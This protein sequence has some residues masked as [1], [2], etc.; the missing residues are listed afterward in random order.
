MIT[1]NNKTD[2]IVTI[3]TQLVSIRT[4]KTEVEAMKWIENY[5]KQYTEKYDLSVTRQDIDDQ[6]RYNLIVSNTKKPKLLL[7]WHLDTVPVVNEQ[8]L[9]PTIQE[10]KL[11]GRG[12]LDMKSW[13]A[14]MIAMLPALLEKEIP[15]MMLFYCDEEYNF[16]GMKKF[17]K[18]YQWMIEPD[19]VI[20]PEW[21]NQS[22]L[23][24][25]RWI[26][27]FTCSVGGQS[28]HAARKHLGRNAIEWAVAL[29]AFLEKELQ[30][31][32]ESF[33]TT[34]NLGGL[35]GGL[36][37]GDSIIQKANVVPNIANCIYDIRLGGK[38]K[39]KDLWMLI[40]Q[41]CTQTGYT[42][43]NVSINFWLGSLIQDEISR[44]YQQFSSV[45]TGTNS[46]Y[47][48]IQ[49]INET[50]GGDCLQIGPSPREQA[51]QVGEYVSID[52]LQKTYDIIREVIMKKV[53]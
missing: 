13:V 18:E 32:D 24:G 12:A 49:M 21:T 25:S 29:G 15:M 42:V 5:I 20:I 2:T 34:V 28:A 11:Y 41:F 3:L 7:W 33:T 22:I 45:D 48:D 30:K 10:G 50:L 23:I 9:Q 47:S 39:E 37:R 14:V 16:L 40:D 6:W 19:L 17:V 52:S 51:H 44:Y 1:M 43:N 8:Q 53:G 31:Y 27:E 46:G 38:A 4:D 35:Q 36:K 26:V